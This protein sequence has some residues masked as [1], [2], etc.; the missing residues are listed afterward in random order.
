MS[1]VSAAIRRQP[2]VLIVDDN[3]DSR[4]LYAEWLVQSGFR[5]AHAR[6]GQEALS[7]AS[8]LL[9]DVITVDIALPGGMDG[10][11]LCERLKA[12]ARTR[13]IPLIAV[14]GW[15]MESSVTR[16]SQVGCASVLIKPC[17]P[18]VLHAEIQRWLNGPAGVEQ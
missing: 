7:Q 14:T 2:L 16:A 11:E 15:A 9:P 13:S 17:T 18:D 10:Y 6:S 3:Q 12:D 8:E 4:D 1:L 5:V